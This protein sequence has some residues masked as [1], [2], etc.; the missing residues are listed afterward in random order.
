MQ[1]LT[2]TLSPVTSYNNLKN[3]LGT[4]RQQNQANLAYGFKV[5]Y[6]TVFALQIVLTFCPL[7]LHSASY[8]MTKKCR[9]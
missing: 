7:L 8:Y 9:K 1:D 2:N 5:V 6:V 3:C 4:N